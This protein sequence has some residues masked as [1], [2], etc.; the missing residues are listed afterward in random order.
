MHST[1]I[2]NSKLNV[3]TFTPP[4]D[5]AVEGAA[6]AAG[7]R[8]DAVRPQLRPHQRHAHQAG[9]QLV[10]ADRQPRPAELAVAEASETSTNSTQ[11]AKIT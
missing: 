11:K 1:I 5:R 2:E 8:A 4:S 7:D 3:S 6:D 9:G 10:L